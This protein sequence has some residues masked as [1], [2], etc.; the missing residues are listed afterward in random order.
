MPVG[1]NQSRQVFSCID[2]NKFDIIIKGDQKTN[3]KEAKLLRKI[4]KPGDYI[5]ILMVVLLSIGA[6]LTIPRLLTQPEGEKTIVVNMDGEEIHRFP[7]ENRG[8][9]YYIDFPFT[10]GGEEYTG[11]LEVNDGA[12]R[13]HRLPE[14]IVPLPIHSDM[15][16]ISESYQM[17]ISLPI[18]M[19]ISLEVDE[20]PEDH[21]EIDVFAY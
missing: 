10:F 3:R 7:M 13:L 14:E 1:H 6:F 4:M 12:V 19:Y 9:P 17:I 20:D 2:G 5:L 11:R 15:G 16:W 8:E 21:P 18:R